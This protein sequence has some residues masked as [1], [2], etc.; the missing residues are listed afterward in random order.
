MKQ[1]RNSLIGLAAG[2]A[3]GV[4]YGMNPLFAK[5]L[6]ADG[7]SIPTMLFFRYA[8]SVV[9]I[10]VWMKLKG[11]TFRVKANEFRLLVVLGL[12]FSLSSLFL[13]ES[14][15]P[16]HNPAKRKSYYTCFYRIVKKKFPFFDSF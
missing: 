2:I 11:E 1:E 8:I 9:I 6:L 7:V 12:L 3:A 15:I 10:A 4:S 16:L 14:Y 13:F 5:P